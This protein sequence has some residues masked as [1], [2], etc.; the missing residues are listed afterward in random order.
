LLLTITI[1]APEATDLGH[2]LQKHP[3]RLHERDLGFGKARV[4]FPEA[5]PGRCSAA[6]AIEVDAVGLARGHLRDEGYV[7]DRPYVAGSLL[8]VALGRTLGSALAGRAKEK[9]ERVE[10][11]MPL[12]ATLSAVHCPGGEGAVRKAFEPLGYEV[13][14]SWHPLDDRFPGWG[15][16]AVATVTLRGMKSVRDLLRH[17]FILAPVVDGSKHYFVGLDEVDKLIRHGEGWLAEHPHRDW[18]VHRYLRYKTALARKALSLLIVADAEAD[19]VAGA[20]EEVLEKP[21][22]LNDQRLSAVLEA[23]RDPKAEIGSVV[24]LGCGEGKLVAELARDA[25][26]ERVL[27]LDVSSQALDRAQ[28]RIDRLRLPI[29]RRERVALALGSLVYR[30][31]RLKGFDAA[32]LVEVIEHLDPGRLPALE[33]AIFGHARP[34]RVVVTTPN[35]EYNATWE[36]LPAGQF[37]HR[38]HRFEWTRAEFEGWARQV[39]TRHRYRVRF[40]PIGPVD[41]AL[42]SP[43]QMALFDREPG[44]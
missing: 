7:T 12:E 37:R 14:L 17:L 27:G 11:L 23:L 16:P 22:R 40:E 38:D 25:R 44:P 1:T 29:Q 9:A 43:T 36:S 33:A 8:S 6:L 28:N 24:D 19:E 35:A 39:A 26:F 15:G 20:E 41:P 10:E 34:G 3:D 2:L 42:G 31:D 21:A 5:S 18:V 30:D 4:F 13:E 32:S